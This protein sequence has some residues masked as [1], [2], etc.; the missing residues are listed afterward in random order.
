MY[1]SQH[2][3]RKKD[4]ASHLESN[5]LRP[6]RKYSFPAWMRGLYRKLTR[7]SSKKTISRDNL[8]ILKNILFANFTITGIKLNGA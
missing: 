5:I 7:P 1:I 8:L 2:K 3:E 6:R 4:A